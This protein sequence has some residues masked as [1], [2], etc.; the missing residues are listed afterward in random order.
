MNE[1]LISFLNLTIIFPIGIIG[2][3]NKVKL[4]IYVIINICNIKIV[5]HALTTKTNSVKKKRK[6]LI[7]ETIV[8][9]KH[10]TNTILS[11]TCVLVIWFF[12]SEFKRKYVTNELF[13]VHCF[14]FVT[15]IPVIQCQRI[16]DACI[17]WSSWTKMLTI[18]MTVIVRF[19]TITLA[20]IIPI[21]PSP[22]TFELVTDTCFKM[23]STEFMEQGISMNRSKSLNRIV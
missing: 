13:G 23:I 12:L 10:K 16:K 3:M 6:F 21:S 8:Y 1:Q 19:T 18:I 22:D 17:N 2:I 11:S 15:C 7:S 9:L 5:L 4:I 14:Y 20:Q